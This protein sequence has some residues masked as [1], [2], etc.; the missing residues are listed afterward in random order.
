MRAEMELS[1]WTWHLLVHLGAD[2]LEE[3]DHLLGLGR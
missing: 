1:L 3:V 2:S